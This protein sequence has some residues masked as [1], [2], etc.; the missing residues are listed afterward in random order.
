MRPADRPAI[1]WDGSVQAPTDH[2]GPGPGALEFPDLGATVYPAHVPEGL[3]DELAPLYSSLLSTPRWFRL[4]TDVVASGA[5]V[6][7]DPRDI[8]LFR[9]EGDTVDV[10]NRFCSAAQRAST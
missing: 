4:Y 6:L 1:S 7:S 5:I 10:L 3:A 2:K 8:L 9:V